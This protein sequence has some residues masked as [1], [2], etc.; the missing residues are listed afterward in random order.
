MKKREKWSLGDIA[1]LCLLGLMFIALGFFVYEFQL[2]KG[3]APA[4]PIQIGVPQ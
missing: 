2:W 3:M 4:D 1:F